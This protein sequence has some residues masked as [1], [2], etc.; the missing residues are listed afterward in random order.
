MRKNLAFKVVAM[1]LWWKE[2]VQGV[3]HNYPQ[4]AGWF[5]NNV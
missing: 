5:G 3:K 2:T 1:V 4:V